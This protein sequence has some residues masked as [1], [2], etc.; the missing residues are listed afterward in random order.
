MRT[1][2]DQR[3]VDVSI[4]RSA[5]ALSSIELGLGYFREPGSYRYATLT[6][7]QAK[8]IVKALADEIEAIEPKPRRRRT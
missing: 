7:E 4:K 2:R 6:V 5:R 3:G 1:I 8:Q